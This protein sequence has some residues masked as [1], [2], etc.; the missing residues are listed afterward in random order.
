MSS[1]VVGTAP[2]GLDLS[3][4]RIAQNDGTVGA[5][6]A[7]ATIFVG[8]RFWARTTN[9]SADLAYDDWFVLVAL[10]I[11][12]Y[13]I[14]Y[15]TTVP[16][17]K[18]SVLLLYRRIFRLTW[19]LYFCAFLSI[20]YAISV[21]T[22]ISV[23]CVPSSFFWTQW[24]Y[25]LSGGHCR[26]NLYQF[27]LWNGVANLFTDVIILCLP[28][29]IV[30]SLQMPKGQ[31]WAI[32][33]IFLLGGFVCVATIVRISAIT[34]MKDSVDITWVIGD[35]MIWSN[36]EPCIGIVSACLPTLRPLLRQIPQLRLWGIFGSS[37][38]TRDYKMTGE[39]TSGTGLQGT[40]NQSAYR[41]SNGKKHRYWPEEDEIYLTTDVGRASSPRRE[42]GVIPSNGSTASGQQPIAMQI[43]VKKNFDWREDRP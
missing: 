7:I 25:P 23:A 16:M 3:A 40:G 9:K 17:V 21:S 11:F 32:S 31:K 28:M 8:L 43:R 37:G 14:L 1:L 41:S 33:G 36:V 22:T 10:I 6:M 26:I 18:L 13:V 35:A 20:G 2:E 29:P 30:W 19:S 12:A 38:L 15:A 42:E 24:V 27:Y 34:K 5:V 4:D 39:G